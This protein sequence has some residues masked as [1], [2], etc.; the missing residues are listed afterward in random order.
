MKS[1]VDV[2]NLTLGRFAQRG[3]LVTAVMLLAI[4]LVM[5]LPIPTLVLDVLIGFS[6]SVSALLLIIAIY[7]PS[8]LA[9]SS[10]PSV[11]L[12]T[13]L[14]RLAISVST[15]RQ[16]L[17]EADGGHVIDVFGG[18]VAGGNLVVGMVIFFI[19][20]VVNF[21]VVTKGSERVAEVAARFTLDGMPGKQMSIDSDLRAGLIDQR[22]AKRRRTVLEKESQLF[23]AMDGA[24]KFVKGDAIAGI[25][26]IFVN[27]LG[28]L[29][30][31]VLQ[32]DMSFSEAGRVFSILSI[33]DGLVAQIPS[34]LVSVAAGMT[35][36]RVSQSDDT[37]S[38]LGRDLVTQLAGQP[39]ATITAGLL[40]AV[41][42]LIP[43]MPFGVFG[44]IAAVLVGFSWLQLRQSNRPE[45]DNDAPRLQDQADL[46]PMTANQDIHDLDGFT[47][48]KAIHIDLVGFDSDDLIAV[49]SKAAR[50]ARNNLISSLG[51]ALPYFSTRVVNSTEPCRIDLY[52]YN[53]PTFSHLVSPQL[54]CVREASSR[55]TAL[56]LDF[57]RE[58]DPITGFERCWVDRS[59]SRSLLDL[60]LTVWDDSTVF[61]Q[62]VEDTLRKN[63]HMLFGLQEVSQIMTALQSDQPELLKELERMI[64][65]SRVAEVMQRIV[66][67]NISIRNMRS[68]L[69]TLIE[70][71]PKEREVIML[72]EQV[73]V[74]L[75]H[76]ICHQLARNGVLYAILLDESYEESI[77]MAVRQTSSG[78]FLSLD[79]VTSEDFLQKVGKAVE[80]TQD[81]AAP[82]LVVPLDIRRYIRKLVEKDHFNLSVMSFN[83]VLPELSVQTVS[84]IEE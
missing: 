7:L 53:V 16:I 39:K 79:P 82:V 59:D 13:T 1:S 24:M 6:I 54:L 84:L 12:F 19:I 46:G 34:L 47:Q 70:W 56:Q 49:Y 81:V 52:L 44:L 68:I 40:I 55:L 8:P 73:R 51:V 62:R 58:K 36:T 20:T 37:V 21:L 72:V 22:E 32:H 27:L 38:S 26:I 9:F 14:L 28:G 42:G 11:L 45:E 64:P 65:V 74:G 76:Q 69:Q 57:E 71:A 83:E 41:L 4:V 50:Q 17:L 35:I 5:I 61:V 3:E 60:G 48:F 10:F 2:A 78:N 30:V 75:R 77:R 31:G 33:G 15:T 63:I 80:N 23:G 29:T 43:G 18:F 25:V 66:S 67:E